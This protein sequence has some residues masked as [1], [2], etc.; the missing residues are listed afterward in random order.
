MT[1]SHT[2]QP[3]LGPRLNSAEQHR[4]VLLQTV[5]AFFCF[6]LLL[7]AVSSPPLRPDRDSKRL[8]AVSPHTSKNTSPVYCSDPGLS[9]YT[10]DGAKYTRDARFVSSQQYTVCV[11]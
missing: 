11:A 10:G 3:R 8:G 7:D 4:R 5:F 2:V 6:F 1:I 9:D